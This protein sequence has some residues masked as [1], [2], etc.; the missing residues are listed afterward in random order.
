[1]IDNT[2]TTPAIE[3]ATGGNGFEPATWR[4]DFDAVV[5]RLPYPALQS[6]I[7]THA[8]QIIRAEL[9]TE[10]TPDTWKIY[11][12][13]DALK[14][15]PPREYL[16]HGLLRLPS[17]SIVYGPPG[18][19]KTML[20]VDMAACVAKGTGWLPPLPG[21]LDLSATATAKSA[22]LWCDFDNGAD[23]MHERIEA[24]TVG[25]NLSET[26]PLYYVCMPTPWLDASNA[27]SM[28][29]L[30]NRVKAL[31]ARLVV[32]D[33]LKDVS[34]GVDENSAE[35]GDVMSQ[36]RRL[37]EDTRAAVSLIHHQ[38]KGNGFAG[39]AGDSL[40]G[41]SSIE[42]AL[43]L[44][45]LV[46]REENADSIRMKATKVRG[47]EVLPF[48]AMFTFEH[49]PGTKELRCTKFFGMPIEDLASDTAIRRTVIELV[50]ENPRIAKGE[51]KEKTKAILAN[52]GLTRIANAV[53]YLASQG[54][55]RMTTG[56]RGAKLYDLPHQS[57][58]L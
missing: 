35:M 37:A 12:V 11:T 15:R 23:E 53:D 47:A 9:K 24:V 27:E 38:R 36:C 39:R 16:L 32:I 51:L 50:G 30:G 22:V 49:K 57:V 5:T 4:A 1:M 56:E 21:K 42:A 17:L 33:N 58:S 14:P 28:G 20:L 26:D 31:G 48:G 3:T 18:C 54:Q 34:G 52:V 55:L 6:K 10:P 29:S 46:E 40:R 13:A 7:K 45:L 43:D 19:L 8:D 2:Y 44:A 25:H 41:H